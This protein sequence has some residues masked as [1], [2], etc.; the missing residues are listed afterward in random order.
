MKMLWEKLAIFGIDVQTADSTFQFPRRGN[1]FLMLVFMDNNHNCEELQC[2]N[3]VKV[4]QKMIFM[5]G[6][7]SSSGQKIDPVMLRHQQ[8]VERLSF[9]CWPNEDLTMSNFLLWSQA[10]R[11]IFASRRQTNPVHECVAE[12]HH[13]HPWWWCPETDT[14]LHFLPNSTTMEIYSNTSKKL[15]RYTQTSQSQQKEMGE[16]CSVHEI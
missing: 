16:Y 8:Q 10:L 7:L 2:L 15:N 1:K 14:L 13:L 5:S 6:V 3:R 11:Y 4:H 12:T 9:V